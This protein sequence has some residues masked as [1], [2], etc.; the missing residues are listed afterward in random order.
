[1]SNATTTSF[2]GQGGLKAILIDDEPYSCEVLA[3]MLEA[4]CPQVQIAAICKNGEEGLVAI[5]KHSPD[6]VFL[7]VEMPK[8]NGFEML[9]QLGQI[10]FHIIFTTS[11]DQYALKAIRFSA[12][13]YLLKPVDREELKKAVKKVEQRQ[14]LP[15]PVQLELLMQKIKQPAC[16]VSKIALPTMEGL[17]LIPID[18][19]VSCE[20]DN[21]Y[22][23][24]VLKNSKKLLVTRSLKEIEEALEQHSFLRVHRSFL[25][26]LNEIEKYVK[27][28]GG[29]VVMSNGSSI[30]VSKARKEL[31][32][33][34]LQPSKY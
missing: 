24:L 19:I 11:Y 31:L 14:H 12:L 22:T 7:D 4:D 20:S 30:D 3:A 26:N 6:V 17:Q 5:G 13:D 33:Q 8:L 1:M 9:E 18:S 29:Y 21:N 32:M 27:G 16:R 34:K 15:L 23:H 10:D 2:R 25:I 28:E